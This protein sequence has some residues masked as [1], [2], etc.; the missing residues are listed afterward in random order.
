METYFKTKL[1][2]A[3]L[4]DNGEPINASQVYL[5]NFDENCPGKNNEDKASLIFYVIKP[6]GTFQDVDKDMTKQAFKIL[7]YLVEN[8]LGRLLGPLFE[9]KVRWLL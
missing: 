6:G 7:H 8:K 3:L 9:Q 4:Q 1:A 2:E 5:N